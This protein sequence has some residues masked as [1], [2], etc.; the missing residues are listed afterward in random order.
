MPV[1]V[2]AGSHQRVHTDGPP[3]MRPDGDDQHI[4][5][6]LDHRAATLAIT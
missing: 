5:A 2:D 4:N 3:G 1:S 6:A